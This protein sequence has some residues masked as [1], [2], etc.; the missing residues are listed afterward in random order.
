MALRFRLKGL[1]E[2][3]IDEVRCPCCGT[4]SVEDDCFG[5][6]LTRVTLVG[7]VVIVDCISFGEIFV[8]EGQNLGIIDQE[9]LE[10]A[11]QLDH[12]QTGEPLMRD[13]NSVVLTAEVLNAER[14]GAVH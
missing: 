12:V 6:E 13:L 1:A 4:Y 3:F 14:K 5:T 9:A 10:E 2:T 7:I 8:P 11:V